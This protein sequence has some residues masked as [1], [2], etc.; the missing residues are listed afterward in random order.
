MWKCP[1]CF[2]EGKMGFKCIDCGFDERTDFIRNRTICEVPAS[3]IRERKKKMD[4]AARK[5]KEGEETDR[6]QREAE[7]SVRKLREANEAARKRRADRRQMEKET[8][9]WKAAKAARQKREAAARRKK[10]LLI[11]IGMIFIICISGVIIWYLNRTPDG[12][13]VKDVVAAIGDCKYESIN[14]AVNEAEDDDEIM[15]MA[16][17][18]E[19][20]IVPEGKTITLNLNGHKLINK[21]EH[22][23]V[24]YGDLSVMGEGIID[25]TTH[26]KA[27]LLNET[28]GFANLLEG[29]VLTRSEEAG[30]NESDGSNSYY[31]VENHGYMYIDGAEIYNYGQYSSNI[32]N[33]WREPDKNTEKIEAAL[34]VASG[35]FVGGRSV[36][37]NAAYGTA[38]VVGGSFEGGSDNLVSNRHVVYI[39][40][41]VF[42]DS[43]YAIINNGNG[44][45][46]QEGDFDISGGEFGTN[47]LCD[48][49][50]SSE[51]VVITGGTYSMDLNKYDDYIPNDYGMIKNKDGSY[52]VIEK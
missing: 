45:E 40:G 32:C 7:E 27:A 29:V 35:R 6:K 21:D 9:A 11:V 3:D 26:F 34:E 28:S 33:G 36:L 47:E 20:V 24:N 5:Q 37:R 13:G 18:I 4:E 15:L 17:T 48:I 16:D 41:G 50:N 8:A 31:T 39:D 49:A 1:V 38:L 51:P 22:T 52:S 42:E 12:A 46:G 30:T 23:I 10:R 14:D 44:S 43:V 19:N 2:G 25:N